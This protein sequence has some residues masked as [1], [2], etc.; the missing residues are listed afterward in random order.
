MEIT[1]EF[2]L[3]SGIIV[4]ASIVLTI[5]YY[6]FRYAIKTHENDKEVFGSLSPKAESEVRSESTKTSS[7]HVDSLKPEAAKPRAQLKTLEEALAGTRKSIWGRISSQLSSQT[8]PQDELS[9]IEEVLF[10]SDMGPLTAQTLLEKVGDRLS[11]NEKSDPEKIRLTLKNE[12]LTFFGE[13]EDLFLK[14]FDNKSQCVPTV[15][16]IAGV[17]GAGKT[18]TIGK[19]ASL[20]RQKG[21][22]TMIVA[23]DTF[24]AAADAQ[25]KS[26]A[27]RSESIYFTNESTKDPSA[28]A[29]QAVEKAKADAIDLVLIDTA[30][31][32]HTQENLMEELKKVKRVMQKILPQAPHETLIVLDANSGQNALEQARQFHKA[33]TLTGAILTKLDGTSKGG[34]AI[35]LASE[36]QLPI[37]YIGVGE[38]VDDLRP[39]SAQ[40][41]VDSIL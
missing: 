3:I 32:L 1:P 21:L 11:R 27:E 14:V 13:N 28:I 5:V 41:F 29:Y 9:R 17:N 31:R 33:L 20:A 34:V 16:M 6:F 35:G 8:S 2:I 22:K 37:R 38:S 24:R 39:F 15:W 12:M 30:G 36:L 23:G 18:T 40:N 25:L 7:S 26:W 19:M 4:A 10:T